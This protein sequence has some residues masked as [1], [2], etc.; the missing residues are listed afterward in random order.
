MYTITKGEQLIP[1]SGI[2]AATI[3]NE[4]MVVKWVNDID[5]TW[6]VHS[7]EIQSVDRLP[8]GRILFIKLKADITHP[9]GHMPAM[10][11]VLR[12]YAVSALTILTCE[13]MKYVLLVDQARVPVG[14][15]ISESV[16]GLIDDN[17]SP[18]SVILRELEEEASGVTRLGI[19]ATD[20][21]PLLDKPFYLSPGIINEAIYPFLVEKEISRTVLDAYQGLKQ[22]LEEEH[23]YITVKIVPLDEVTHHCYCATTLAMLY[24][25][26]RRLLTR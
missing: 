1:I 9:N 10:I 14:N 13:N 2:E 11:V 19:T 24:L 5:P 26:Q 20:I 25:Y 23:E 4:Q 12:D 7:L 16:A 22:G 21:I 15:T 3:N 17:A 6:I 8:S 18:E